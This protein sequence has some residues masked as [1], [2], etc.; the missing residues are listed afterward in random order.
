[1]VVMMGFIALSVDVG[2]M[3]NVQ[4]EMDRAVDA[5][6]L[7]G[8][9]ALPEGP[10]EADAVARMFVAMNPVGNQPLSGGELTVEPGHWNETSRTFSA[11]GP[12]PLAVRVFAARDDQRP[13]FFARVW[14]KDRFAL[15]SSAIAMYQPRDIMVV[16]DYSASM[17]DDSEFR[18]I[19]VLGRE[20]IEDN[21]QLI[22]TELGSPA[23]G[24]LAFQPNWMT[25]PGAE[26]IN[27]YQPMVH[28][29]H[30]YERVYV[31]STKPF[32][33]VRIYRSSSAYKSFYS[34]GAWNPEIG[35]YEQ[36]LTYDDSRRIY[37]VVVRSGHNGYP[38]QNWNRYEETFDFGTSSKVRIAAKKAWAL[39]GVSYPYPAGSWNEYIDYCTSSSSSN[40]NNEAGYLYKF[41]YMNYVNYLLESRPQYAETPDLWRTSEQ[42]VTAVKNAVDV[43]LGFMQEMNTSD[44]V[45]LAVYNSSSGWG[46]LEQQLTLDYGVL[47]TIS[48]QRQAGHYHRMTNIAAGLDTAR[49]ELEANGREGALRIIVLMTDGIPTYPNSTS[50][51]R[52][53]AL[54]AA[55]DCADAR[56]PVVTISLGQGADT[57]LMQQIADMTGGIHFRVP[58][59][60]PIAEVEE[61]LRDTFRRI[62]EE[63]PLKLVSN[64]R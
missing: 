32:S 45:G 1:M 56:F 48:R 13:L 64:G 57:D 61:D 38:T 15:R 44:R 36:E 31:T 21:L 43:F 60:R 10:A 26:P 23:Y 25:V 7:A 22:Y 46:E 4:T 17:N 39:N 30:R 12:L 8:A 20:T 19:P 6:A 14:G 5:G 18:S 2:Y 47:S 58:G 24:T 33:R 9:G 63:R 3:S 54:Q 37:K 51:A 62:A 55:Q 29:Q 53:L 59:G 27:S 50:Y 35:A 16:L 40:R 42:P 41:G 11:G 52:D 34:S 49:N 28:V